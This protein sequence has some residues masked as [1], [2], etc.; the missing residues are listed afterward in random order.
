M[1][2]SMKTFEIFTQNYSQ[3]IQATHA[4]NALCQYVVMNGKG[5][6]DNII[7]IVDIEKGQEFLLDTSEPE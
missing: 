3:I 4:F 1:N 6:S 2:V 7:A 5:S